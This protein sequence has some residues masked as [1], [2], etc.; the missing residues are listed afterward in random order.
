MKVIPVAKV[1]AH[2]AEIAAVVAGG[3]LACIPLRG[4]YRI[5]ADARSESAITRLAQSKRRAH[6]RPALILV[7]D[8]AAA[9]EMVD[10]TAWPLTLR[11]TKK[12]WPGPLTLVLPPSKLLP[13]KINKLLSRS[14][15]RLG[16]RVPDDAVTASILEK[17]GGPLLVSSANIENKPG[18]TSAAAVRQRFA[19]TVDIWVDA[20]DIR[21]EP[22]STLVD[23]TETG[24]E[25]VREGAI[26]RAAIER[27]LA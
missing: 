1:E 17:C 25:L 6:N 2:V 20:G 24:W 5:I 15:G 7:A 12:L 8:L 13:A 11:A 14:T 10:G 3:G 21:P 18:S 9:R 16:I 27:A 22:P 19:R 23:I 26:T 4:A